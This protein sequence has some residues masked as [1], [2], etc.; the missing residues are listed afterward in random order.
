MDK[1]D[2]DEWAMRKEKN[3]YSLAINW[4]LILKFCGNDFRT[5]RFDSL[6]AATQWISSETNQTIALRRV[7]Y[8]A[9]FSILGTNTWTWIFAFIIQTG[10]MTWTVVVC[11]T[12]RTTATVWI[13]KVIGQACTCTGTISFS[14]NG[15]RTARWRVTWLMNFISWRRN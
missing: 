3:I 2:D 7:I 10:T 4:K 12:F 5:G 15:I 8:D 6:M 1:D 13:S 11:D 14:A 9:T